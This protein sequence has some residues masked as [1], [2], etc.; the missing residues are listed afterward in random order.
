[1][2]RNWTGPLLAL[3]LCLCALPAAASFDNV[4]V[5]PRARAMGEAGVALA[6]DAFAPYFNP[7]GLAILAE[8][9]A[10]AS[11]IRPFALSFAD[12]VYFGGAVP[13]GGAP[14]WWAWGCG[15]SVWSTAA[16]TCS[17]RPR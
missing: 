8:P 12:F 14:A 9:T 13:L 11:Y 17:V 10:G 2:I 7:A 5:S 3:A 16:W 6:D 15:A 4:S 1:M